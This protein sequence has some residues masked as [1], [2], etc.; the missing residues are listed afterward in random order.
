M[1]M[2]FG[3]SVFKGKP[4]SYLKMT[5]W[6]SIA[7][8]VAS[9]LVI[10]ILLIRS[11]GAFFV[12][13]AT[14]GTIGLGVLAAVAL[15]SWTSRDIRAAIIGLCIAYTVSG[16]LAA[17]VKAIVSKPIFTATEPKPVKCDACELSFKLDP[18]LPFVDSSGLTFL[19]MDHRESA[20][21]V[22]RVYYLEDPEASTDFAHANIFEGM[23]QEKALFPIRAN[24][25]MY[26]DFVRSNRRFFVFGNNDNPEDWLLR[27]LQ[28]DG[29]T[30]EMLGETENSYRDHGLYYVSFER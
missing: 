3:L 24:V 26:S 15:A 4:R 13:Y 7:F 12:R 16:Q 8:L 28:A 20:E 2:L 27:K 30:I 23:S 25:S 6:I 9:P 18:T 17:E 1:W 21:M 11:H 14:G 22:H 29:A 10:L 19:E 5:E